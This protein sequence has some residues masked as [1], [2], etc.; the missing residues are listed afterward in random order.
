MKHGSW[1]HKLAEM[2]RLPAKNLEFDGD[3]FPNE[4][5][6]GPTG[7][8]KSRPWREMEPKVYLKDVTTEWWN[9]YK[10]EEVVLIEDIDKYHV[11]KGYDLKIWLDRYSFKANVKCGYEM[12]IRPKKIVI[13]SNFEPSDIWSDETTLGPLYRRLQIHRYKKNA[14]G[15]YYVTVT[16]YGDADHVPNVIRE[17]DKVDRKNYPIYG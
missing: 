13:T 4:W 5:H 7:C 15:G 1:C 14:F 16:K 11:K 12:E 10:N 9:N 3:L 2:N 17:Y 8:G 6:C